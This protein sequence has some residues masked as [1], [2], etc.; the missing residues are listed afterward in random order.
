[1][2]TRRCI[3]AICG[4]FLGAV[5]PAI[6]SAQQGGAVS[7]GLHT[8]AQPGP[9]DAGP[10]AQADPIPEL[11][12]RAPASLRQT[13]SRPEGDA[14]A[15]PAQGGSQWKQEQWRFDGRERPWRF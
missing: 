15:A 14:P 6:A 10:A 4:L 11:P 12:V 7:G 13:I 5:F 1:M 8:Q 2:L 3:A 9:A